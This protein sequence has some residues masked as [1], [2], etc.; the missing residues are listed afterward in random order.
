MSKK[1]VLLV[2]LVICVMTIMAIGV[3]GNETFTSTIVNVTDV[4]IFDQ[5]GNKLERLLYDKNGNLLNV[6]EE[7]NLINS[8]EFLESNPDVVVD[9]EAY[10]IAYSY[11][12]DVL[13]EK[14]GVRYFTIDFYIKVN[15]SNATYPFVKASL[16]QSDL[17]NE[18][19]EFINSGADNESGEEVIKVTVKKG[20]NDYLSVIPFALDVAEGSE[21]QDYIFIKYSLTIRFEEIGEYDPDI[22]DNNDPRSYAAAINAACQ[23]RN[24]SCSFEFTENSKNTIAVKI[25]SLIIAWDYQMTAE[26]ISQTSEELG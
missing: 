1:N 17:K 6:D 18:K 23:E 13:F 5:Q 15:P 24:G 12:Q 10:R 3:L 16:S 8:L 25:P 9:R 7:G 21:S 4:D 19:L 26:E 22:M 14:E 20:N 2:L 11:S